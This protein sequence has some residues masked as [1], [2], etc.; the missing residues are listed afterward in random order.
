MLENKIINNGI[1]HIKA[2][3]C[4]MALQLRKG[5]LAFHIL[6]CCWS[7]GTHCHL[8]Q[9]DHL[10]ISPVLAHGTEELTGS[11]G[12]ALCWGWAVS[13]LWWKADSETRSMLSS[14]S[15][16]Q[17]DRSTHLQCLLW[18]APVDSL[19]GGN[20]DKGPV[21]LPRA[22]LPS[23]NSIWWPHQESMTGWYSLQPPV[24]SGVVSLL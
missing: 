10:L 13:V 14:A 21:D 23:N 15:R 9:Q 11:W 17:E 4:I 24:R 1:C 5:I 22:Q 8:A 2:K 6:P 3:S 18:T 19:G 16:S 7:L 20:S 12:A